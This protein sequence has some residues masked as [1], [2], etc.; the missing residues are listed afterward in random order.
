MNNFH[1]PATCSLCKA[2]VGTSISDL[3][4]HKRAVHPKSAV[5]QC[6]ECEFQCSAQVILQR[7]QF[8]KHN[9]GK[10]KYHKIPS[11]NSRF[12][13]SVWNFCG[14]FLTFCKNQIYGL[15]DTCHEFLCTEKPSEKLEKTFVPIIIFINFNEVFFVVL[16]PQAVVLILQD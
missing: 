8:R 5:I 3:A 2:I 12:P 16:I 4:K 9:I 1:R 10:G 7:H 6:T 15:F 11:A 13:S 14:I